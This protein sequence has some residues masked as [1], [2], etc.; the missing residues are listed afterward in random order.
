[1]SCGCAWTSF[2]KGRMLRGRHWRSTTARS[3]RRG[4]SG[5]RGCTAMTAV[6]RELLPGTSDYEGYER[7]KGARAMRSGDVR[8]STQSKQTRDEGAKGQLLFGGAM[9]LY[10]LLTMISYSSSLWLTLSCRSLTTTQHS[11]SKRGQP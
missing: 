11:P 8:R 4:E 6:P 9:Y 2:L 7:T 3:R 5:V 1:M 10:Y